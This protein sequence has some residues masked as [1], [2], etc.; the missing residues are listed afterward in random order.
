M[1]LLSYRIKPPN[2]W[3]FWPTH[4][5]LS[6]KLLMYR[7]AVLCRY[8]NSFYI[9]DGKNLNYMGKST[10]PWEQH[11]S[12]SAHSDQKACDNDYHGIWRIQT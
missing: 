2:I 12:A 8:E 4:S 3:T 10:F 1:C 9:G 6:R 11:P 5:N 7:L